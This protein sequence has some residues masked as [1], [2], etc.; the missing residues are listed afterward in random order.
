MLG[1]EIYDPNGVD[2]KKLYYYVHTKTKTGNIEPIPCILAD[3]SK[4]INM[5]V[6]YCLNNKMKPVNYCGIIP[7]SELTD[8]I[9]I[10]KQKAACI[11]ELYKGFQHKPYISVDILELHK[12]DLLQIE[13][14]IQSE[15]GEYD[16]FQGIDFCQSLDKIGIRGHHASI[17]GY[18][19]CSEAFSVDFSD[20][21]TAIRN[22]IEFWKKNDTPENVA[23]YARFLE[24]G[25]KYGWD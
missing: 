9:E 10:A 24:D 22:F 13:T 23:D 11:N 5:P 17:Y 20:T 4:K 21:E 7:A 19:F 16:N 1:L 25:K 2:G 15:L 18:V 14:K 6:I 8:D 3:E 12:Q